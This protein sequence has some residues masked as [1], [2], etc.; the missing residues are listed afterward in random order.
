MK[1][2]PL[3][4]LSL[5]ALVLADSSRAAPP[6]HVWSQRFG[7]T[8]SDQG[9][10]VALDASG[11]VIV[12]G[13]FF[14]TANFGG[15]NLVSAGAAD[16]FLA[17]YDAS[18][19]HLWSKRFGGT[20]QEQSIVLA[21]DGSGSI[22]VTGLFAGTVDF[23]GGPLVSA[24][25]SDIFLVKYDA[26]GAHLWSRRFGDTGNDAGWDVA[27]D[28]AGNLAVVGY[29]NGTIN[30]G[31]ANLVSAGGL[32][33]VAGR[34]DT[35]GV[36]QWSARY[37]GAAADQGI[38]VRVDGAGN[39][40]LASQST[41]TVDFGGGALSSAGGF[42]IMLAKLD[43]GGVHQWSRRFGGTGGDQASS[44]GVDAAGNIVMGSVFSNTVDFGGG[45]LTS[46][47]GFDI[48]LAKYD[49]SGAHQWSQKFGG[50]N[51][52]IVQTVAVDAAGNAALTGYF[53]DTVYFGGDTLTAISQTQDIYVAKLDATGAHLWSQAFGDTFSEAGHSIAM[54]N[55]SVVITGYF[56]N[57]VDF[58][59][60][61][62]VT[63][64]GLDVFVAKFE[65][66]MTVPVLISRFDAAAV[67][68]GV[69]LKWDF[70]ADEAVD[71]FA[72][73]RGQ[74]ASSPLQIASGDA[75]ARSYLD[76]SAEPGQTYHYELVIRTAAGNEFRSQRATTTMPS[77]ST[78]VRQNFPN[79]FNP[80]TTIEYS[81]AA[82]TPVAI[83]IF[84]A[85]GSRVRVVDEGVREPGTYRTEW[86]GRDTNGRPVSS[87]VYF[88]RF[89]GSG[90]ET[91][92]M[93]LLK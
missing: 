54:G 73:F 30:L 86:D 70:A 55:S 35:N 79:P 80:R 66:Q 8:S 52:D 15:V 21:V 10:T 37:G 87:G 51:P 20:S 74:G 81:L 72:L 39:L 27:F 28:G 61:S 22:V 71:R 11:N 33:I 46:A 90:G 26:S 84:D 12:S 32:D 5:A 38:A 13:P 24:G 82:R 63:A 75:R 40:C 14:G 69:E 36:H 42:D 85:R 19:A 91:R 77:P 59:G 50:V 17:K 18:G 56:G 45:P 93:T 49:A 68:R 78:V 4:A 65:D 89:A 43:A 58:G 92:K 67:A 76:T 1:A 2:A 88:Y 31:G 9:N 83:E 3:V 44:L 25:S 48:V 62:L 53:S 64:G 41:G 16:V 7:G 34:F 57:Q 60:G 6:L 29:Y 23:G 47:G